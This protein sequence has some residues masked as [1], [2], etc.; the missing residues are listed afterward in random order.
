MQ[1]P[2]NEDVN[3]G[4]MKQFDIKH[5][6]T[7]DSGEPGG[8]EEKMR[9][10][11][12]ANVNVILV[13]RPSEDGLTYNE[14]VKELSKRFDLKIKEN[15]IEKKRRNVWIIGAGM[16]NPDGMTAEALTAIRNAD[17]VIGPK[18][19]LHPLGAKNIL[20][21]FQHEKII[22]YM[23]EHPEFENVAVVFSGDIGFY[24]GAKKLI[25]NADPEW[26]LISICGISSVAYLCAKIGIP[27]QDVHLI[28][29]H[30]LQPNAIGEIRRNSKV[31]SLLSKGTDVNKLCE[32]M[33]LYGMNDIDV[34]VG[35]KLGYPDEKLTKGSPKE[36]LE[37]EFNDLSVMLAMNRDPDTEFPV[38]IPDSEF[39]RSDVPMTK[40][41]VRTLTVAKLKLKDDSVIYDV[42][43]GSGSVSIEMARVAVNGKVYAVEMENDALELM[44]KNKIRFAADNMEIINGKAPAALKKLPAPTHAF[45]GGSGGQLKKILKLLV[46]KN[47]DVRVVINSVTIETVG[48][49]VKCI[50]E[51]GLK[52]IET[53]CVSVS[54]SKTT[55]KVHLMMAQ[56]P[57][58]ITVCE[59]IK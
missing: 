13:G 31:F 12:R 7:K 14:V 23:N 33:I 36:L 26:N 2:F 29:A 27:W 38:S 8:F 58:Y 21:E 6:V 57:I 1:G 15:V 54:R 10:A 52:E 5:M 44:Q 35:E 59:G 55:D 32:K 56:N 24:S 53:I 50:K 4:M 40:S 48:E 17:L 43:A 34:I 41:E 16:G 25:E 49:T 30:G 51:L 19:M 22:A 42:G 47:P 37:R 28:S 20:N 46:E 3:Y 39:I 45:I 11:E 9:A 18:R